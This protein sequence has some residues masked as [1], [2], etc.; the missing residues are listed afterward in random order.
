MSDY[1]ALHI[2]IG[3]YH[4]C[5]ETKQGAS[6]AMIT[7]F[8]KVRGGSLEPSIQFD[9]LYVVRTVTFELTSSRF[10]VVCES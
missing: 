6:L 4:R 7:L 8:D 5:N 2:Q 10:V 1:R 3:P 9:P